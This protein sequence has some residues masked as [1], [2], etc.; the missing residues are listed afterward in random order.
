MRRSPLN[1]LFQEAYHM[2]ELEKIK[3]TLNLAIS[4]TV[5]K[6][7]LFVKD[8]KKDF[9]RNSPLN[10]EQTIKIILQ[11]G[12]QSINKE[13]SSYFRCSAATPSASAFCQQRSKIN[14][15]AFQYLFKKFTE[16]L[17]TQKRMN[18]YQ[19]IA[20]DGSQ[21]YISRD[22][23]DIDNYIYNGQEKRGWNAVH[24]N[25][26]YD[27][28]NHVYVDAIVT[29]GRKLAE[30]T[31][32]MAML[33]RLDDN[34]KTIIIADRGYESYELF[35]YLLTEKIPFV[36]RVKKPGSNGAMLSKATLPK[37]DEYDINF[38]LKVA[39]QS[40]YGRT[41]AKEKIEK[42]GYKTIAARNLSF[43][44]KGQTTY[45]FP[46]VRLLKVKLS[47]KEPEY[48]VT[49]L[50]AETFSTEEIKRI[51]ALRWG[52]ETSFRELKYDCSL[53]QFHSKKAENI[54]QEIFAKLTMYNFCQFISNSLETYVKAGKKYRHKINFSQA[55]YYCRYF[56]LSLIDSLQLKELIL[57][58]TTPVR[59]DRSFKRKMIK[60][61]YKSFQY[62]IA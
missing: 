17:P 33:K 4:A 14:V 37:E 5:Q 57:R 34:K 23:K 52:I 12:G 54:K 59:P 53:L 9:V 29:P 19:L 27:L 39:S 26:F 20:V 24:L 44:S 15:E 25:A 41:K 28:L 47:G 31:S 60:K 45:I 42:Q 36:F 8:K 22:E 16:A 40:V 58:N 2:N 38:I 55:I 62:R 13:L 6:K 61:Q 48:L 21:I 1:I 30:Q 51:Y 3:N 11:T 56:Y 32:L 35:F 50:E 43:F 49:N 7:D 10:F 18:G 46:V